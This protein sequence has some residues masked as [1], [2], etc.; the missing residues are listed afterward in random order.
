MVAVEVAAEDEDQEDWGEE[1]LLQSKGDEP[2]RARPRWNSRL[3]SR[4]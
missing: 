1:T 3:T 2:F 4:A